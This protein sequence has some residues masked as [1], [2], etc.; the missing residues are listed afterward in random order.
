[1]YRIKQ[2]FEEG[3]EE[4]VYPGAVLL[5]ARGTGIFFLEKVGFLSLTPKRRVMQKDTIFDL[6]SLTKPL[7]T[8]LAMMKLVDDGWVELD[9]SVKAL[10]TGPI[11]EEK[12]AMTPR[13]LLSHSAGFTD[14]E[15]YYLKLLEHPRETRK[16]LLRQWIM[17][18]PL[19]Y[20][21]GKGT[22][23]SD[24]GFMVLEWL[25]GSVSGMS[26]HPFLD[27]YFYGKLGLKRT[28]IQD[29]EHP[30]KYPKDQFAAT[31]NCPWRKQVLQGCVHDDNA[32]ALGGYS[33]HAGLFGTAEEVYGIVNMLREHYMGQRK[34]YFNPETVRTFLKRQDMIPGSTWALGWD[35]P[36]RKNS[37]SGRHFSSNSFGHLGFTGT[38][39]WMDME[40]DVVVIFL[41]NRV[42]PSRD[43]EKIKA[44]RPRIHDII[45]ETL[46]H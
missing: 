33:G 36:S 21:P 14:W 24:I 39:V 38:S 19:S 27:R 30:E 4:G 29:S 28:F 42:H 9:Q 1:M 11:P 7:A 17:E 13:M 26:M 16:T 37:S 10:L 25:I 3:A 15:P 22:Q 18:A 2:V 31:E 45:M 44:F 5:V 43:N 20:R 35:T 46:F 23:Y 8:T 12:G 32:C 41:T 6:A 34:D 40:K